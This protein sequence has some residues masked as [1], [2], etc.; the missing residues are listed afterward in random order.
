MKIN[1]KNI[2]LLLRNAER[3]GLHHTI[4]EFVKVE[5]LRCP[6]Q[7]TGNPKIHLADINYKFADL[8]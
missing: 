7:Q 2:L 4:I 5:I 1:F 8:K 3:L 6:T